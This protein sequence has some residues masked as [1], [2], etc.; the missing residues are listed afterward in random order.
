MSF[1]MGSGAASQQMMEEIAEA[2]SLEFPDN[3]YRLIAYFSDENWLMRKI[4]CE[5]CARLGEGIHSYL[6]E[7]LCEPDAC[8]E[9]YT[10]ALKRSRAL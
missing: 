3:L 7:S 2:Y 6:F 10:G 4:A 9:E 5:Y 1:K 8:E